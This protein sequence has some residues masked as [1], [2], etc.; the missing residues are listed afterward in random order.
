MVVHTTHEDCPCGPT[1]IPVEC[2]DGGISYVYAH[3]DPDEGV[4]RAVAIFA[5]VD[6]L[7]R[8]EG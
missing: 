6:E 8:W 2:G 3:H 4:D 7:R 5:A 1:V